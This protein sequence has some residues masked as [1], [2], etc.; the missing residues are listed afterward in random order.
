[1]KRSAA[2]LCVALFLLTGCGSGEDDDAKE[3][4]KT[5]LLE[6]ESSVVGDTQLT[7]EQAECFSDGI[8]DEVGVDKLQEYEILNEDLE[9]IENA[10]PTDMS[11]D[12]AEA[13][14]GV[15]TDCVNMTELIEEQIAS[16]DSELTEEQQSCI[17]DAIDEDAIEE[18]LAASFQGETDNPMGEMTGALMECVMPSAE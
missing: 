7:E 10:E 9:I 5:S 2:A 3:N 14:A 13:M 17:T 12:D 11:K 18:G 16:S 6:E 1:M 8:V 15:M 4:I